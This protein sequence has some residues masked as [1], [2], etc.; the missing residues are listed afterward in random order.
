MGKQGD[1]AL[2]VGGIS[3]PVN[4]L[5]QRRTG[6]HRVKE[7]DERH[8]QQGDDRLAGQLELARNTLQTVCNIAKIGIPAS[9]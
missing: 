7:K 9:D 1:R 5:M 6:R 3:V 2:V 8:Q 4:Q